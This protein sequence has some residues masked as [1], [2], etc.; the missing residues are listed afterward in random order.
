MFDRV[1]ASCG[2]SGAL[3]ALLENLVASDA[4]DKSD[5]V[6]AA[7][8]TEGTHR[9]APTARIHHVVNVMVGS[10][11]NRDKIREKSHHMSDI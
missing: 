7:E 11:M 2:F 3:S 5:S 4:H 9:S 1:C 6:V 8:Y 10:V